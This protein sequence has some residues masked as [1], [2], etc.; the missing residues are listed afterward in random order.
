MFE[1]LTI[2]I[3]AVSRIDKTVAVITKSLRGIIKLAGLVKSALTFGISKGVDAVVSAFKFLTS[4]VETT[5]LSFSELE[6]LSPFQRMEHQVLSAANQVKTNLQPSFRAIKQ[7]AAEFANEIF[8]TGDE[9]LTV[10]QISEF[11]EKGIRGLFLGSATLAVAFRDTLVDLKGKAELVGLAFQLTGKQIAAAAAFFSDESVEQVKRIERLIRMERLIQTNRKRARAERKAAGVDEISLLSKNYDE[12]VKFNKLEND[13]ERSNAEVTETISL[14]KINSKKKVALTCEQ[15][16]AKEDKRT[17]DRLRK[18]IARSQ[19]SVRRMFEGFNIS[20][21]PSGVQDGVA[22]MMDEALIG[23]DGAEDTDVVKMLTNRITKTF[24]KVKERIS[25]N[26]KATT[27]S[28]KDNILL[29]L[30]FAPRGEEE[31]F[32]LLESI[33]TKW[34]SAVD[35]V[36]EQ[37]AAAQERL[38]DKFVANVAAITGAVSAVANGF[39][40]ISD[41]RAQIEQAEIAEKR[42][43]LEAEKDIL[44]TKLENVKNMNAAEVQSYQARV[45]GIT[46]AQNALDKQLVAS[47]RKQAK[48]AKRA[49]ILQGIAAVAASWSAAAQALTEGSSVVDRIANFAAV[50]S[51]GLGAVAQVK[52]ACA[53]IKG[54]GAGGGIGGTSAG[55]AGATGSGGNGVSQLP[56]QLPN[57]GNTNKRNLNVTLVGRGVYDADTVQELIELIND[58]DTTRLRADKVEAF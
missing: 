9:M 43:A 33:K 21:A 44:S 13:L 47:E 16:Q 36:A 6:A 23:L 52:S 24:E 58:D 48:A 2:Y 4:E 32:Q 27:Q 20:A 25:G 15:I 10:S 54:G 46:A 57:S 51:T 53:K 1:Q 30:E 17:A 49:V 19:E 39:Q 37:V 26:L 42:T 3:T 50:L 35:Q 38:R 7:I 40:Q 41:A 14:E 34:V 11:L 55:G 5:K 22:N 56:Q 18:A 45:K 12:K 28:D 8:K 29:N 31:A